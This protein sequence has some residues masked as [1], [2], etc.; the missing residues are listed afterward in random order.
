M[1]YNNS[2]KLAYLPSNTLLLGRRAFSRSWHPVHMHLFAR[3][4]I[5]M[6]N[7]FLRVRH[8][9]ACCPV[10]PYRQFFICIPTGRRHI[11]SR[12]LTVWL[13]ASPMKTQTGVPRVRMTF[14][15]SKRRDAVETLSCKRVAATE[16]VGRGSVACGVLIN[17]VGI[18]GMVKYLKLN[19]I[20]LKSVKMSYFF[21]HI[22]RYKRKFC[23]ILHHI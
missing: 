5:N 4:C 7:V 13:A 16:P 9:K 3:L 1:S 2:R 10:A 6:Q 14:G 20:K 21:R 23:L 11:L 8:Q 18:S 19:V 17:D 22:K 15:W 12:F